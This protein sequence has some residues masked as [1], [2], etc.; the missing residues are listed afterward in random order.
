LNGLAVAQA[1]PKKR[2]EIEKYTH[3]SAHVLLALFPEFPPSIPRR[4]NLPFWSTNMHR[5]L[6]ASLA[7]AMTVSSASAQEGILSRTGRALD[8]AGRGI[9]DAVDTEVA[10]GQMDAQ[11]REVLNRVMRRVEWDKHLAGSTIQFEVQPGRTVILR[12]SVASPVHKRRAAELVSSTVGVIKVVDE[13]AVAKEVKV[14]ETKPAVQVIE[15][16]TPV[17]TETKVIVKP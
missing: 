14:I 6:A 5:Y 11:D 4:I 17:T 13:L 12:G 9:R 7:L 2:V 16:T 1:A 3:L 15:T 10:R 8:N